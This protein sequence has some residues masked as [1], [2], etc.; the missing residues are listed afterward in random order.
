MITPL[1]RRHSAV[2]FLGF[3]CLFCWLFADPLLNGTYLSESDLYDFYLPI[4]LSPRMVW[5]S[6]EFAGIPLFADPENMTW[7][8]VHFL[9]SGRRF[10]CLSASTGRKVAGCDCGDEK[11]KKRHPVLWGRN[12]KP[13]NRREKEKVVGQHAG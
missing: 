9:F 10:F 13:A 7:Y 2:V 3:T 12:C 6:F 1:S 5:S 4:F 8:P 11:H